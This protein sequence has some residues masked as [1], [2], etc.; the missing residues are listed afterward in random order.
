[1][2]GF[3][4]FFVAAGEHQKHSVRVF[5]QDRQQGPDHAVEPESHGAAGEQDVTLCG[6]QPQPPA[7]VGAAHAALEGFIDGDPVGQDLPFGQ[8][9]SHKALDNVL[10]PHNVAVGLDFLCKGNRG[11]VRGDI[12][13]RRQFHALI[14]EHR[15]HF[16]RKDVCGH[17]DIRLAF[18]QILLQH[19]GRFSL[20]QVDRGMMGQVLLQFRVGFPEFVHHAEQPRDGPDKVHIEPADFVRHCLPLQTVGVQQDRMMSLPGQGILNGF[21]RRIVASSGGAGQDQCFHNRCT[22]RIP[23][24]RCFSARFVSTQRESRRHPAV[25]IGGRPERHA[26]AGNAVNATSVR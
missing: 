12:D 5:L 1:M 13:H 7:G 2:N 24:S 23:A 21:G 4:Q 10:V 25:S 18:L 15:Q 17:D 22:S 20:K 26:P 3:L 19:P 16:S 9:R 14:P 11:V 6:I 8:S